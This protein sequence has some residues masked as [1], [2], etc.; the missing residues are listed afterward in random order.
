MSNPID[1]LATMLLDA[2][3]A[4]DLRAKVAEL[5]A[6]VT[7]L[8]EEVARLEKERDRYRKAMSSITGH[9]LNVSCGLRRT[10]G[11]CREGDD[12][13]EQEMDRLQDENAAL[14]KELEQERKACTTFHLALQ[15]MAGERDALRRDLRFENNG[16][17]NTRGRV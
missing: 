16:R 5:E 7:G 14:R 6:V 10:P 12:G 8:T 13:L 9:S 4:P 15:E 3:D 17:L 11:A 2:S 1:S